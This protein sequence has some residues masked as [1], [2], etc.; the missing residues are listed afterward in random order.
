MV[1]RTDTAVALVGRQRI[2]TVD[3]MTAQVDTEAVLVDCPMTE[4]VQID[5]RILETRS[6]AC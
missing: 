2:E 4:L 3:G 1:L 5:R 6:E